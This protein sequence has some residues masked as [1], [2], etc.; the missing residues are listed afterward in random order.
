MVA[1]EPKH[2]SSLNSFFPELTAL[3]S[4]QVCMLA[5]GNITIKDLAEHR[6]VSENT[7]KES[8]DSVQKKLGVN[9]IKMLRTVVIS[10]VLLKLAISVSDGC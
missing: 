6:G 4:M 5:F 2:F 9:S 10:R 3:Q 8:M 1:I 7:I